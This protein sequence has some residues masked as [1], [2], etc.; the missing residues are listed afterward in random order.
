MVSDGSAVKALEHP[1]ELTSSS[2]LYEAGD[3]AKLT[4]VI[5]N[6]DQFASNRLCRDQHVRRTNG[7][8]PALELR[9]HFSI[10]SRI[11]RC[12][13]FNDAKREEPPG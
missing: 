3:P 2:S 6:K 11:V 7:C 12:E 4:L 9:A 5:G 1:T 10:R 8:A 13:F